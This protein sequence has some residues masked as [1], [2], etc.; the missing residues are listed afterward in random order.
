MIIHYNTHSDKKV[1]YGAR[2]I[3]IFHIGDCKPE[4]SF[5]IADLIKNHIDSTIGT[6]FYLDWDF[7]AAQ[8]TVRLESA[9]NC[10]LQT[11]REACN[12][13][14]TLTHQLL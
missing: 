5:K 14:I 7:L 2:T 8:G 12:K 1:W 13:I 9:M 6:V 3:V 10:D 11:L 4:E